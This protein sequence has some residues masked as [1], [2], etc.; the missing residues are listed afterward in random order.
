M[1]ATPRFQ[2][3]LPSQMNTIYWH[4]CRKPAAGFCNR[5]AVI[6]ES[7]HGNRKEMIDPRYAELNGPK[8]KA[9]EPPYAQAQLLGMREEE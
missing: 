6:V 8:R 1:M 4:A 7:L 9:F 3:G 2:K 5:L